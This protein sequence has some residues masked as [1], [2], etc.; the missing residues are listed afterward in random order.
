MAEQGLDLGEVGTPGSP[1]LGMRVRLTA[2]RSPACS[3]ISVTA[4]SA[5][6]TFNGLTLVVIRC[7][8]RADR[9]S[10]S[11]L[12][13]AGCHGGGVVLKRGAS[14]SRRTT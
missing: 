10:G 13:P 7:S 8:R 6:L 12:S 3:Y 5:W 1:G 11:W 9:G 4:A 2:M 14:R